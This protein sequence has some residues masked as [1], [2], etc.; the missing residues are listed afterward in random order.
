MS[1]KR[2]GIVDPW[3]TVDPVHAK[4]AAAPR[5][6]KK[7]LEDVDFDADLAIPGRYVIRSKHASF[8]V[9][10]VRVRT[11]KD[12]LDILAE[13]VAELWANKYVGVALL[14]ADMGVR[15]RNLMFNVPDASVPA[16][17]L[18]A[19]TSALWFCNVTLDRGLAKLAKIL[20]SSAAAAT[21]KKHG[22]TVMLSA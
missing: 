22:I 11:P 10:S 19:V 7:D 21:L 5:T 2:R 4:P 8:D 18:E 17:R 15:T 16:S 3:R 9:L 14:N 13:C 12:A 6:G 20:R 1:E